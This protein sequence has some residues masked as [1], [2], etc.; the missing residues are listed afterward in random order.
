MQIGFKLFAE[1]NSPSELVRQAVRAEEAGFDFLEI[2]DHFHP[3]LPEHGHAPAAWSVLPA[4]AMRTERI[5]LGTGVTCP[6]IR[7]HPA[8]IAQAAATTACLAPG[9]VFVGLGTGENLNEHI[10]GQ[11]WPAIDVRREMLD[12]SI[13]IIR[14]LWQGGYRTWR[15]Q[16][17]RIE[18]A[19][20]F[21]IPDPLPELIVAAGGP[22]AA[23]L[24]AERGDGL[25][26]VAA[27]RVLTDTYARFGGTGPKYVEVPLAWAP[28]EDTAARSAHRLFRFGDGGWPVTVELPN[29]YNFDAATRQ[30][31]VDSMR[32]G[33]ACGPDAAKHLAKVQEFV[34][35]G[36]DHLALI[37]AGPDIDGFFDFY[38]R[39]LAGPI[40]EI[41]GPA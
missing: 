21:D 33:F 8:I 35:A 10:V 18:S 34:D 19:Q 23:R 40:R 4:I 27:D 31:T 17:L 15:G 32:E 22:K 1:A 36:F 24:A 7:Y 39:E 29:P 28:D 41:T 14:R 11:G 25:F 9:R 38:A 3:W 37:N 20:V 26:A 30:V 5:R 6:F 12:E 13:E 16:H 2:S